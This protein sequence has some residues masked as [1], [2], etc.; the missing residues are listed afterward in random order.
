VYKDDKAIIYIIIAQ[1][2]HI[3]KLRELNPVE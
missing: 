1:F 2:D 3:V